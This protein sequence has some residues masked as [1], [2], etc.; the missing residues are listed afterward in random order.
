MNQG[1]AHFGLETGKN[2]LMEQEYV[3]Y[4]ILAKNIMAVVEECIPQKDKTLVLY[5]GYDAIF[6]VGDWVRSRIF[7][8]Y[9]R[10]WLVHLWVG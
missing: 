3:L 6:S 9:F 10:E 5:T 1:F 7:W 2:M 4:P 8:N